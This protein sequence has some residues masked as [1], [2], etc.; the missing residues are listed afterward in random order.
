VKRLSVFAA[1]IALVMGGLIGV[2][3]PA[4][5]GQVEVQGASIS[6]DDA[7]FYMPT[8]CSRFQFNWSNQTGR[9]LL[10]LR[11]SMTDPFGDSVVSD[12]KIGIESGTSG[13]F[14]RQICRHQLE[15]GLGP[16]RV[17]LTIEDYTSL[18]GGAWASTADLNFI[19]RPG[20]A[21]APTQTAAPAQTP[22]PTAAK[23][24]RCVNK[25]TFAV[26]SFKAKKCPRGWVKR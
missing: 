1:S 4:N 12:S 14:D 18:G 16:Y 20:E 8:G 15:N 10:A 24:I 7:T 9:R 13:F 19:P 23:P 21:P 25:K 22:K 3:S 5:A 17:T 11:L 6:W 26:K 2:A